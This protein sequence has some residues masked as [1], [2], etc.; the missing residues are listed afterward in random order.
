M[1]RQIGEAGRAAM[2]A[3]L[4]Q[5]PFIKTRNNREVACNVEATGAD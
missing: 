5:A 3:A 2:K 4:A 1:E